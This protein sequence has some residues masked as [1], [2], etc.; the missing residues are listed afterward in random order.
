MDYLNKGSDLMH[1][2][3]LLCKYQFFMKFKFLMMFL[4]SF[5]INFLI[6]RL[7]VNIYEKFPFEIT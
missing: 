2:I 7:S 1:L 3:L 6:L 4:F 5:K